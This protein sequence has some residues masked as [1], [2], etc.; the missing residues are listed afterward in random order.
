MWHIDHHTPKLHSC[1][2]LAMCQVLLPAMV[3]DTKMTFFG[4][5]LIESW[6]VRD[7]HI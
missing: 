3:E 4:P 7:L 5:C 2:A 6:S 1:P